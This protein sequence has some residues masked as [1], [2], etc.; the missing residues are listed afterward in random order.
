[1]IAAINQF[2][3][4]ATSETITIVTPGLPPGKPS[5]LAFQ[6]LSPTSLQVNWGEPQHCNG[7]ISAYCVEYH[8]IDEDS[9]IEPV[10]VPLPGPDHRSLLVE[11]LIENTE[12]R[13][14]VRAENRWGLGEMRTARMWIKPMQGKGSRP[15]STVVLGSESSVNAHSIYQD[16]HGRNQHY[17]EVEDDTTTDCYRSEKHKSWTTRSKGGFTT[18]TCN[19]DVDIDINTP[20]TEDMISEPF[21]PDSFGHRHSGSKMTKTEFKSPTSDHRSLL[22]QQT[23]TLSPN[24]LLETTIDVNTN[25]EVKVIKTQDTRKY[26]YGGDSY[27]T[28]YQKEKSYTG[29]ETYKR[30]VKHNIKRDEHVDTAVQNFE[31]GD[32]EVTTVKKTITQREV[33]ETIETLSGE[34]KFS[35][36]ESTTPKILRRKMREQ[37]RSQEVE[38]DSSDAE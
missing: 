9:G 18:D 8:T 25:P 31:Y 6:L 20:R 32:T 22:T 37:K 5:R 1:M 16:E 15:P 11:N 10:M 30:D 34:K 38:S 33:H 19:S 29:Q 12:Y 2:G 23:T 35:T 24:R 13:Y 4:S 26:K 14:T 27:D 7:E 28:A 36:Q 17:C 21:S 3:N